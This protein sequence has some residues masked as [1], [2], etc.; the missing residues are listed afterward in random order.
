MPAT[1]SRVEE[2][3][4]AGGHTGYPHTHTT[5]SQGMRREEGRKAGR[6]ESGVP[7]DRITDRLQNRAEHQVGPLAPPAGGRESSA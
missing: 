1:W 2:L 5:H 4:V 3:R 7:Q 6:L